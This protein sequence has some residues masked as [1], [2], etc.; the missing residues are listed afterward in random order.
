MEDADLMSEAQIYTGDKL[1]KY[2]IAV[3]TAA[4]S[5]AKENPILLCHRGTVPV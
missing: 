1:K 5:L 3:N 2:E 4:Q